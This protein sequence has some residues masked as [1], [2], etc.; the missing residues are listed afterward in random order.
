MESLAPLLLA[1]WLASA[2]VSVAAGPP[3][4][5]D[6]TMPEAPPREVWDS[7]ARAV[8]CW[9]Y[10]HPVITATPPMEVELRAR[11]RLATGAVTFNTFHHASISVDTLET[12]PRES[13]GDS[14]RT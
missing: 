10:R 11:Q 9:A 6:V 4:S 5:I 3:T 2:E 8:A 7:L 12:C 1:A 14:P 13:L